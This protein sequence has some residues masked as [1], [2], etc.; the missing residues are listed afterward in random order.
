M[1][2]CHVHPVYGARIRTHDPGRFCLRPK[3]KDLGITRVVVKVC[4]F[5]FFPCSTSDRASGLQLFLLLH[6]QRNLGGRQGPQNASY[7]PGQ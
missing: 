2:K 1:R 5:L 7:H 3:A 6:D 4:L